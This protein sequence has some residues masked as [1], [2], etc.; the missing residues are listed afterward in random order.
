MTCD[1]GGRRLLFVINSLARGGAETQLLGVVGAA[2]AEGYDVRIATLLPR[3]DFADQVRALGVHVWSPAP[4]LT[5]WN[6]PYLWRLVTELRRWGPEVT[7]SFLF[8]ATLFTRAANVVVRPRRC[9]SSVR[10]ERLESRLRSLLFRATCGSDD[11]VVTNS[12]SARR[13]LQASRTLP[14]SPR[15]RVIYNG[16][17]GE[18]IRA[19]VRRTRSQTRTDLGLPDDATV[20]V[21]VG[22]LSD[23]KDW[24]SLLRALALDPGHHSHCLLAG[25]GPHEESLRQLVADLGLT[26]RVHLLGLRDDVADLLV[27]ADA[28]V[29]CSRYEGTPNVVLEALALGVPVVA[30]DVGACAE[31]LTRPEDQVVA[32]GDVAALSRALAVVAERPPVARSPRD[33]RDPSPTDRFAWPTVAHE[34]LELI[35]GDRTDPPAY[36]PGPAARDDRHVSTTPGRNPR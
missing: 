29:L 5:T 26:D 11:Y 20:L 14:R 28:M 19:R 7:V 30:T 18:Q 36:S 1:P 6:L 31:L 35:S 4:E 8:Q 34:W 22:R 23:Q 25:T 3:N 15:V 27:A 9:I 32:P 13:T 2:V 10:N 33:P 16:V 21:G 17:D 24:G 12:R